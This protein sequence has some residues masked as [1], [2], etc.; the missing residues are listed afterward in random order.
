MDA[1]TGLPVI[2]A[3]DALFP[4]GT[5][6][7]TAQG[8]LE[9]ALRGESANQ[10]EQG[11]QA[12]Q[13]GTPGKSGGHSITEAAQEFEAYFLSYMMGVMRETVP[14]GPYDSKAAKSFYS[15]YDAEIGKLAAKA[16][17]MGLARSLEASVGTSSTPVPAERLSA[18][19]NGVA[20]G[21]SSA[22]PP[23]A[24]SADASSSR[25]GPRIP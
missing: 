25:P 1:L 15:F 21:V 19:Y 7:L 2:A 10:V 11:G 14:D 17:G 9:R 8:K 18:T 23:R 5:Q 22:K 16:G 20:Q 13:S 3:P 4:G 24:A 6:A 12:G